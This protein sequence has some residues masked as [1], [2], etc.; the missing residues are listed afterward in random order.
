MLLLPDSEPWLVVPPLDVEVSLPLPTVD[1]SEV[2]V[3]V[4]TSV[5]APE[6][7]PLSPVLEEHSVTPR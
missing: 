2:L 6:S 3:L 1:M 7:L 4:D 5:D